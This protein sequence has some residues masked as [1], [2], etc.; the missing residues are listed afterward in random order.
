MY[1]DHPRVYLPIV[2]I[3]F[4]ALLFF[5]TVK[6]P[7]DSDGWLGLKFAIGAIAFGLLTVGA[8]GLI[9]Y[10]TWLAREINQSRYPVIV[11]KVM[12]G[13]NPSVAEVWKAHTDLEMIGLFGPDLSISW[14]L[15][16]FPMD[17]D[18]EFAQKFIEACRPYYPHTAPIGKA[19]DLIPG[20]PNAER[21]A[22]SLIN[23]M[24]AIGAVEPGIGNNPATFKVDWKTI[25]ENF[26][27]E[28]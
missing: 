17:V 1:D 28:E 7:S 9:E 4:A 12:S 26:G 15:R 18:F 24:D 27:L 6:L 10:L 2:L 5:I 8:F 20:E 13:M 21:K 22:A 25:S 19:Y 14:R 16:A 11:A 3:V 23:A